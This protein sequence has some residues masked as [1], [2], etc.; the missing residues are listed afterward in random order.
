LACSLKVTNFCL[1]CDRGVVKGC[2]LEAEEKRLSNRAKPQLI[3]REEERGI[4]VLKLTKLPLPSSF[5]RACL[6]TKGTTAVRKHCVRDRRVL[7][8]KEELRVR[9]YGRETKH[10]LVVYHWE[11]HCRRRGSPTTGISR[12]AGPLAVSFWVIVRGGGGWG[13]KGGGGWGE[14]W[15]SG[16]NWSCGGLRR[17]WDEVEGW[18]VG[19]LRKPP[20]VRSGGV[21]GCEK[22]EM[23][24]GGRKR[25]GSEL[26]RGRG[27]RRKK[28]R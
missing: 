16:D 21:G 18:W 11:P 4:I 27:D 7:S 8:K 22:G 24:R 2:S 5:D 28:G 12:C 9:K 23:W 26:G 6:K 3:G 15:V 1:I 10:F 13:R 14:R 20:A 19:G 25:E 17:G